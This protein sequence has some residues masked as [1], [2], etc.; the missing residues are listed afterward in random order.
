M[1]LESTV[2][3]QK[4][5]QIADIEIGFCRVADIGRRELPLIIPHDIIDDASC[6][7]EKRVD[8]CARR[9]T[10]GESD[11]QGPE[12]VSV[13]ELGKVVGKGTRVQKVEESFVAVIFEDILDPISP[14][15]Q[16]VH[17]LQSVDSVSII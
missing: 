9:G 16:S 6:L 17:V 12:T 8:D 2:Q 4:L 1:R 7:C 3:S 5:I 10:F 11:Q 15:K 14:R 13:A